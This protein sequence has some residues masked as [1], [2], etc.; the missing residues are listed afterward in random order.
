MKRFVTMHL[1]RSQTMD[2]NSCS[3]CGLATDSLKACSRCR[4]KQYCG[5]E[6]QRRDWPDHKKTCNVA[7]VAAD[8][9]DIEDLG[10]PQTLACI[11]ERSVPCSC[12]EC[13]SCC[14]NTPGSYDP[15]HVKALVAQRLLRYEDLIKDYRLDK[16]GIP[17]FYIRPAADGEIPGGLA[18]VLAMYGGCSHLGE[19]GCTL[20]R[21]SMPIGCVAAMPC[22]P[23]LNVEV[24]KHQAEA[25][26]GNE[27]GREVLQAFDEANRRRD[28][29]VPLSES[30]LR[31]QMLA[32]TEEQVAAM[33]L[34]SLLKRVG[35]SDLASRLGL[36]L[37]PRA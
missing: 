1:S 20:P 22:N 8:V 21:S 19:N 16:N 37:R 29:S 34:H 13:A 7:R 26:W 14:T 28:P 10:N 32:I 31:T 2:S 12:K 15:A 24:D 3:V 9:A 11:R 18:S 23:R 27:L 35:A 5:R 36:A 33:Q 30:D 6:C 25:V 4:D 17:K